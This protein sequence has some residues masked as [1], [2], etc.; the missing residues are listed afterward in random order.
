MRTPR[1]DIGR[2]LAGLGFASSDR[3]SDH[4]FAV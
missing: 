3:T 4:G 1:D 2:L